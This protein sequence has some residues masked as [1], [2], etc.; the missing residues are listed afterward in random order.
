VDISYIVGKP[1]T[2]SFQWE[3][4]LTLLLYVWLV[5]DILRYEH[6][7]GRGLVQNSRC[8]SFSK[9]QFMSSEVKFYYKPL[10]NMA[11]GTITQREGLK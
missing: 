9:L 11:P 1:I 10:H 3:C 5:K 6:G 4:N 8:Y 2:I 7:L